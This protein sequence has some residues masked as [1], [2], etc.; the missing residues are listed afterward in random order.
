MGRG[1]RVWPHMAGGEYLRLRYKDPGPPDVD[2]NALS[3]LNQIPQE[4]LARPGE[5]AK[6][7]AAEYFERYPEASIPGRDRKLSR[8]EFMTTGIMAVTA[9]TANAAAGG[10]ATMTAGLSATNS[11]TSSAR[12]S[13]A[14]SAY[15][16][17]SVMLR[18]SL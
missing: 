11:A 6:K 3:V 16:I 13:I 5:A 1:Q 9:R 14:P 7:L 12:R 10:P 15:R 18:P 2:P 8:D 4:P 17:S